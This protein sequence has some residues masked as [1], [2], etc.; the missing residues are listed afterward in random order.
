LL[1]EGSILDMAACSLRASGVYA[2]RSRLALVDCVFDSVTGYP[3]FQGDGAALALAGSDATLDGCEFIECYTIHGSHRGG[4]LT[5]TDGGSLSLDRCLFT[6]NRFGVRPWGF[7]HTQGGAAYIDG[8]ATVVRNCTISGNFADVGG[9]IHVESGAVEIVNCVMWGDSSDEISGDATVSYSN[10]KGG[11]QGT[12]NIDADPMFVDSLEGDYTLQT[13]SPCIDAGSP[14]ILNEDGSPS[15][16]G[17][18]GGGGPNP[19]IPH[20]RV[21]APGV[22]ILPGDSAAVSIANTGWA[23]LTILGVACP[24]SFHTSLAFPRTIAAGETLRV[25]ISYIGHSSVSDTVAISHDDAHQPAIRIGVSVEIVG[26]IVQAAPTRFALS[27]N[28]P[29]P[30]NPRTV[31]RFGIPEASSVRLAVYSV[32]GQ[33]V[34]ILVDG[35]TGAGHHSVVWDGTDSGGRAVASGVYLYRLVGVER[36]LVRRMALLR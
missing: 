25:E 36:T 11:C 7:D 17:H 27:Q 14:Y 12:G 1:D 18:T 8:V 34:R 9:G 26:G 19:L 23:D 28:A 35:P 31:L 2:F 5:A 24:D 21:G 30:F 20:I 6:G 4:A 13:S 15:D 3:Q 10:I 16:I 32:G 33:L 29:N 22:S